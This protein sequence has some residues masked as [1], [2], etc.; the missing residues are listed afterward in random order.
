MNANTGTPTLAQLQA[1]AAVLVYSDS[2]FQNATALGNNLADYFDWGGRVV[3]APFSNATAAALAGRW[4]AGGYALISAS[5]QTQPTETAPVQ[6]VVSSSPLVAG[7]TTLTATAAFRS[8]GGIINGGV[9]V[10]RWGSSGAPLIV[11]GVKNGK[12]RAELNFYPPSSAARSDLWAGDGRRHHEERAP[13]P[14][15]LP[16]NRG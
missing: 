10:A 8:S 16:L 15:L 13:I 4:I 1:Y 5:G 9:V 7:V 6:I 3:T 12:A 14:Q 11:S 2:G